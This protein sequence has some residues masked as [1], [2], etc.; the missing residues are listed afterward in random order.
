MQELIER[1][2]NS[3]STDDLFDS[4]NQI[5]R[6]ADRDP[7]LKNWFTAL[8]RY[9]RK[10]LKE[11]GFI[12][13]DQANDEWNQLYDKGN[14]LLRDRYR[15]HTDRI[16]DETKFLAD[17]F[18]QDPQNKA[19]ANAVNKLFLDLGND[20]NG[21]VTFKPHLLK[22][23]SEVILPALFEN[24]RYV[25]IPRIEVSDPTID[26]VVENLVIESDNLAPNA[27]EFGSDNYFRWGRKGVANKRHQTLMISASGIQMDLKDVS[28]YVKKKAGFPSISDT[29]VMDVFLGGEGF[30]FKLAAS[31]AHK[32][33]SQ[34]FAKVDKVTVTI[35]NLNIKVKQSKHKLLFAL[36]KP[37]LLSVMR[38]VI[39]KVLEQQIKKS[40]DQADAFAYEIHQTAQQ[41][42]DASK[43]D[44]ENASNFIQ[45]HGNAIQRK[46]TIRKEKAQ[47]K[48]SDT[49]GMPFLICV[50]S[51]Y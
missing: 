23:V 16:L 26:A 12:M 17:Q 25:P 44:P 36:A 31:T 40:F 1:F 20:D 18:D 27:L 28:Y 13:Q 3:T 50:K 19:F 7:E 6:D 37:I 49:K 9:I 46:I 45:A 47:E 14:F 15:T 24:V 51:N 41:A 21:K 39:Q 5:Y 11:Q 2:A 32:S 22:D 48:A 10:C 38:P 4:L 8:D 35:K 30:S 43:D 33:D 42:I 29:G 34:H